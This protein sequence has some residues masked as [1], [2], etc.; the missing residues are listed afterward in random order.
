MEQ[1]IDF[2]SKS[3]VAITCIIDERRNLIVRQGLRP[4]DDFHQLLKLAHSRPIR[5]RNRRGFIRAAPAGKPLPWAL[6][7]YAFLPESQRRDSESSSHGRPAANASRKPSLATGITLFPSL[8]CLFPA[9]LAR[10][11]P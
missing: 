8:S 6:P 7:S 5:H 4:L 11:A 3:V 2:Y 9:A 10:I 1:P